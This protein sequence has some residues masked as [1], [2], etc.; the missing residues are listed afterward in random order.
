M[1]ELAA[2]QWG[3]F[4]TAQARG[5]GV[6]AQSVA[7]MCAR[8]QALRLRHG[9]YRVS[10][11]GEGPLDGLR[12]AWVGLEPAVAVAQRLVDPAAVAVVSHRSAAVL[13]QLGDLD[14]DVHEFRVPRRRQ[15]RVRGTR[16]HLQPVGARR[17][18]LVA[19]LPVTRV[20][21]TIADLAA[22]RTDG[23]HLGGVVRDAVVTAHVDLQDATAALAP[24][25]HHYGMPTGDGAG[26]LRRLLTEAGLPAGVV[27]AVALT[28]TT[29]D[30]EQ[31]PV[32]VDE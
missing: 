19:G 9:V 6:S 3:L 26:L 10:G 17:W 32:A 8:G 2:G 23:G 31:Y 22:A 16:F 28:T 25:A 20:P 4:T 18:T 12:A 14:A 29:P 11:V 1:V 13:H 24:Y 30:M 7:K 21:D 5:L 15:A 27:A